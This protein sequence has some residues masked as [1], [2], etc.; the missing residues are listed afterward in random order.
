MKMSPPEYQTNIVRDLEETQ[1]TPTTN[2]F[3]LLSSATFLIELFG[4]PRAQK[5]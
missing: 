5:I 3:D 4:S 2:K 1:S